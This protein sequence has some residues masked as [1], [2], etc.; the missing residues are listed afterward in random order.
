MTAINE[1]ET[2]KNEEQI[3]DKKRGVQKTKNC[4]L[5]SPIGEDQSEIRFFADKVRDFLRIE[6]L[7]DTEYTLHRADEITE[8][9]SITT[10]MIN[11]IIEDDM[12]IALL[13]FENVNVYYEMAIRHCS[14][15]PCILIVSDV[16]KKKHSFPFDTKDVKTITFSDEEIRNYSDKETY[17]S[18]DLRRFRNEILNALK[19]YASDRFLV[20]NPVSIAVENFRLPERINARDI[21]DSVDEKL[22]SFNYD[23]SSRIELL[24]DAISKLNPDTIMDTIQ[25][26]QDM[27]ETEKTD[28]IATYIEGEDRAF[29]K[30]AEMTALAKKELRTSR[31]A[32]QAIANTN[33]NFFR[34]FCDFGKR[35]DVICKRIMCMNQEDKWNDLYQTVAETCGGSMDLYLTTRKNNFELVVIDEI[36]AFIHFYGEDS[37]IKST[38][39]IK[40]VSVIREFKRIYDQIT[41]DGSY[42]FEIIRCRD[43]KNVGQF[44]PKINEIN[45]KFAERL[46][47]KEKKDEK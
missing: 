19:A 25:K 7:Q 12:V 38:L 42:E 4:F 21:L 18:D 27:F 17:L 43:Y 39:L 36:A 44:I 8:T 9:G 10:D 14:N 6:V 3:D 28:N 23:M 16:F 32:P 13:D 31:F 22:D 5:I 24:S 37:H 34:A 26:M 35:S 45:Q 29:E 30:L 2:K 41:S 46:R 1:K 15:K 33:T 11:H 20:K 47:S 40:S